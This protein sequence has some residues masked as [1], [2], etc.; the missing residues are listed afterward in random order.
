MPLDMQVKLLRVLQTGEVCRIGQ[1]KAITVDLRIIAATHSDLKGEVERGNFREDLFYRLNVLPI[2]IPPLR[3]RREDIILLA[4][5]IL[6]RCSQVLQRSPIRF[7]PRSEAVLLRHHWPGNVRELENIVERA[8][9]LVNGETIEPRLFGLKLSRL[10]DVPAHSATA[11]G[12]RLADAEKET[13]AE[14]LREMNFNLSRASRS[15]GIS[16]ATLYNKIRKYDLPR[17]N[18]IV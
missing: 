3:A 4:R 11:D 1:H 5:H 10:P 12:T 9:N 17:R 15:L 16:R 7:S 8:V 2:R 14:I 18:Q 13:I 6:T